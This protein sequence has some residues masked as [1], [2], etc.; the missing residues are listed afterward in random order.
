MHVYS[1]FL[2]P[3]LMPP[4]RKTPLTSSKRGRILQLRKLGWDYC[5]IAK[6]IGCA[7]STAL[8]TQRWEDQYHT[9]NDLPYLDRP[10]TIDNRTEH[11][12]IRE[13][14]NN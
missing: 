11:C 6:E 3:K 4:V 8:Y 14:K 9:H 1:K 5:R 13:I 7:P 10:H 2:L 12:V